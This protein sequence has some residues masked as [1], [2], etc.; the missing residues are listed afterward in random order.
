MNMTHKTTVVLIMAGGTGGH[1]FPA[2]ATARVLQ[3][4]GASVQWLG[5]RQGMEAEYIGKTDIPFHAID[6]KGIRGK[7]ILSLMLAPF[8]IVKAVYQSFKIIR[9]IKPDAVLGMGGF[10]SGP[11]GLS[12][13]LLRKK[14]IV[15]EQNA[16]SGTTNRILA[17]IANQVLEAFGGAFSSRIT[18]RIVGNPVRE[19]I[20]KIPAPKQ[21]FEQRVGK[22]NLLILGGSLGAKAIN[23]LIPEVIQSLPEAERPKVWHQTGKQHIESC[24]S[25]YQQLC[26]N[27]FKVEPFI[28]AM[29]DAYAWADLV[30]CRAGALT[31]S[32]LS[33]AGVGAILIPFPFA[34]DDHQTKNAEYLATNKAAILIQQKD[35]TK[36]MLVKYLA[37]VCNKRSELA[38]MAE[39]ARILS[40]P[41][42]SEQVAQ[43]CL[44]AITL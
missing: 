2:L 42:A 7:G 41:K 19:D 26:L 4:K 39:K 20:L 11:G 40:Q 44:E 15:H 33:A 29:A 8:L 18:T 31:V 14:L 21:R 35:L 5:S 28:D 27:N 34:V 22:I 38:A 37:E 3:S 10:A 30:I 24:L 25:K 43:V 1:I 6:V 36:T 23:E 13:W 16:L 12:A 9:K 17:R 32:E